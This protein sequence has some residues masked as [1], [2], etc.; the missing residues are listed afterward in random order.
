MTIHHLMLRLLSIFDTVFHKGGCEEYSDKYSMYLN[1]FGSAN[2]TALQT[3]RGG[4][5]SKISSS[6][7]LGWALG[8][9][10]Y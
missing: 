8:Q 4:L 2:Y 6:R 5:V 10:R 7:T 3:L 9:E 1:H